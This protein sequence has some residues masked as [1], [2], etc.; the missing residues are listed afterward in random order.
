MRCVNLKLQRLHWNAE[1][2]INFFKVNNSCFFLSPKEQR[3]YGEVMQKSPLN[4]FALIKKSH[5]SRGM[6]L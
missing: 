4:I 6:R 1:W 5:Q 3:K 2:G